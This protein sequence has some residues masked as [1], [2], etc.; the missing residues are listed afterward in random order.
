[1]TQRRNGFSE[2]TL[3]DWDAEPA[4]E[5]STSFFEPSAP[6]G[7]RRSTDRQAAL[8]ATVLL[9]IAVLSAGIVSVLELARLL[10]TGHF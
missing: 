5:R 2:T 3:F 4:V 7:E 6:T 8:T 1:M 9:A 10:R